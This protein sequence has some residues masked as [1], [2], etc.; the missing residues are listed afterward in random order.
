MASALYVMY[1]QQHQDQ[2]FVSRDFSFDMRKTAKISNAY[3]SDFAS[4]SAIEIT[5]DSEGYRGQRKTRPYGKSSTFGFG[6]SGRIEHEKLG[7]YGG[8]YGGFSRNDVDATAS[9][10]SCTPKRKS[11]SLMDRNDGFNVPI[12]VY[13]VSVMSGSERR[14]LGKRLKAELEQVRSMHRKI[15]SRVINAVAVSSSSDLPSFSSGQKNSRFENGRVSGSNNVKSLSV[16]IPV[17]GTLNSKDNSKD[18][19]TPK[20]NQLYVSSEFVSGKNKASQTDKPKSKGGLVGVKRGIMG[21]FESRDEKK[22][23][24]DISTQQIKPDAMTMKQCGTLLRKLMVHKFGW[25][26]NTPVDIVKL[27][28][29][30]YFK[31]IKNPMDL[32][33]IKRKLETDVYLNPREFAADVRLTFA[34]AMTYNPPGND[35]HIMAVQLN[36]IFEE[37]WRP[38]GSKL[39][40]VDPNGRLS[41]AVQRVAAKQQQQQQQCQKKVAEKP[42]QNNQLKPASMSVDLNEKSVLRNGVMSVEEKQKLSRDLESLSGD[43]PEQICNFFRKYSSGLSQND[44][45]IEVDIDEFD[46]ET[47]F[48]LRKTVNDC[49]NERNQSAAKNQ[50]KVEPREAEAEPANGSRPGDNSSPLCSR[51]G[52]DPGDEDVDIGE[53]DLPASNFPP[54]EIEKDAAGRSSKC[55]SSSSSSSDSGSSTTDSDSASS[56]GSESDADNAASPD[57]GH[58]EQM[59]S[60]SVYHQRTSPSLETNGAKRAVSE[61]DEENANS[62]PTPANVADPCQ[63]GESAPS[64]RQVSPDKRYRAALL[65]NRFAD[66]ILKAQEKTFNQGDRGDPE[67]LRREREELE[68]RQREEKARLQEEAKAAEF[69]R[70]QAEAEAAAEAKRKL[71]I[72][73]EAARLELQQMEKTVELDENTQLLKDLEMLRSSQPDHIPSSVDET[74][75]VQSQDGLAPFALQGRNCLEQFGLFMRN[76]DEEEEEATAGGI[77]TGNAGGIA[78]GNGDAEEGEID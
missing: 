2:N 46:N 3:P 59:C 51:K 70:K 37:K 20:A 61:L 64:E 76:E 78:A 39:P 52:G 19:R 14:E 73:R 65:R 43:M 60:V 18:K 31:V 63:E 45:E 26:F 11:I 54:V 15:E 56:S 13:A 35:V 25:V 27:N 62:K 12:Q 68:R 50:L 67:K 75:S 44:Y 21:R 24:E 40:E 72:E 47:L 57:A 48:E 71:E 41:K 8:G 10:D 58:K 33:T 5:G 7:C 77:A 29:P 1:E 6:A 42:K 69:A 17:P 28:I 74:C 55:S 22:P 53:N 32:G 49:L 38:I 9:E 23:R 30:D 4:D 34:N 16:Q 36:K 66:T